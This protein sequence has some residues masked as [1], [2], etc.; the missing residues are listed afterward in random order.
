MA[1]S[2]TLSSTLWAPT[3]R[4]AIS[5]GEVYRENMGS[6]SIYFSRVLAQ[7]YRE[8]GTD[9]QGRAGQAYIL[10]ELDSKVEAKVHE[11]IE[12]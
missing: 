3:S 5:L 1:L 10:L 9:T 12:S 7:I 2:E 6:V 8:A 11:L 4:I